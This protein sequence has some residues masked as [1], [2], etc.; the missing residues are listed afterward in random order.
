MQE[1]KGPKDT[2]AA[3]PTFDDLKSLHYPYDG[4]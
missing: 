1:P 4:M 2:I 3:G